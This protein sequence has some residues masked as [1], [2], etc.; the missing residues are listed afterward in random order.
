MQ[1]PRWGRRSPHA[2]ERTFH[3]EMLACIARP[4]T[5]TLSGRHDLDLAR[6]VNTLGCTLV[7]AAHDSRVAACGE[8]DLRPEP[9]PNPD[10]WK[11]VPQ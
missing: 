1:E 7:K 9:Y 6:G 3:M 4:V 10:T 8:V 2:V 11:G 5:D